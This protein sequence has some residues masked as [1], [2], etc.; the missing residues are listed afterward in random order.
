MFSRKSC[1]FFVRP[2]WTFLEV[3]LFP[4]RE[5]TA[6]QVRRRTRASKRKV[7]HLI[8]IRHRDEVEAPITD[9]LEEAYGVCNSLARTKMA[10]TRPKRTGR[11]GA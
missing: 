11:R 10:T 3:C 8:Q 7:A 5:V 2:K 9:W 1:Y 4:A 6:P